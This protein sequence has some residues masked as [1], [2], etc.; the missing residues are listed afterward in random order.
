MPLARGI[1]TLEALQTWLYKMIACLSCAPE[2]SLLVQYWSTFFLV[3]DFIVW[4]HSIVLQWHIW[5][6]FAMNAQHLMRRR[7]SKLERFYSII[8]VHRHVVPTASY[9]L[10]IYITRSYSNWYRKLRIAF[11]FSDG[12]ICQQWTLHSLDY[13][14]SLWW[15]RSLFVVPCKIAWSQLSPFANPYFFV[16]NFER[17]MPG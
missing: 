9:V 5:Q 11:T 17:P 10:F 4:Y 3:R 6:P 12:Y 15:K 8:D 1:G 7:G 2:P 14:Q 13:E 16:C